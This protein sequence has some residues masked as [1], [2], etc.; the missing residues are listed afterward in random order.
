MRGGCRGTAQPGRPNHAPKAPH[1]G[2]KEVIEAALAETGGRVS[3]PSGAAVR[4]G[5]PPST[6]ETKIRSLKIN[7][8][9]FKIV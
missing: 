3:G 6:L 9:R 8:Y 5:I 4:L 2:S 7:K 1:L